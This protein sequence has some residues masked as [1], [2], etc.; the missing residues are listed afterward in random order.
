MICID[1]FWGREGE[2][3]KADEKRKQWENTGGRQKRE[4]RRKQGRVACKSAQGGR[5][6]SMSR[7]ADAWTE[8]G[9][10][11]IMPISGVP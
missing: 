5:K 10:P 11:G 7:I 4:E 3:G 9:V 8:V 6:T 1:V 2:E